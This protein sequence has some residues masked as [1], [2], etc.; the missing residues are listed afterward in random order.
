MLAA[1]G[2]NA[3]RAGDTPRSRIP[4]VTRLVQQ[5]TILEND[6]IAATE[7]RDE[8]A[9][10]ALLGD[11]F[12]MRVGANPG[13]PVPRVAWKQ[14]ILTRRSTPFVIEQMA[15]HDRNG[16]AIVSFLGRRKAGRNLFFV[17]VW[18]QVD[19]AWK[20]STRYAS[21]ADDLQALIPGNEKR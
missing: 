6:L 21:S 14:A 17:D 16:T 2:S 3:V 1:G 20:L 15:V 5:F 8:V 11:D 12:E 10:D 4:T 7:G 18:I 19:G 9:I 13:A